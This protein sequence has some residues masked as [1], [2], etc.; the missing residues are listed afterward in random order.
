VLKYHQFRA[1]LGMGDLHPGGIAATH[2]LLGL[3]EGQGIER[4]LEVG[5]GIGNTAARLVERGWHVTALEPDPVLFARLSARPGLAATRE[6]FFD[7]RPPVAYDAL[8]A[9]SVLGLLDLEAALGHARRLL[10]PGGYLACVDALWTENASAA[11]AAAWHAA[12]D[13]LFGI[14]VA[15][16][17]RRTAADWWRLLAA[18]GFE[19]VHAERLPAGATGTPPSGSRLGALAAALR[20]PGL[21]LWDAR[22]R[23]R[24]RRARIPAG[25]LD[26]WIIVAR[27][28]GG[29]SAD[30]GARRVD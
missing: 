20:R 15:A 9:E 6:S 22:F 29:P 14:P 27:A 19:T 13:R 24:K 30:C 17:E 10:R 21:V 2:A 11:Q 16:R 1:L 25:M 12:T 18:Q 5:A 26:S 23:L 28:T 8:I 7:H 3:L 4:V